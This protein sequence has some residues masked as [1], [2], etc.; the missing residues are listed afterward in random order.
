MKT[1]ILLRH[2]KSDWSNPEFADHQR[3]LNP[4]GQRNAP[5]MG[6]RMKSFPDYKPQLIKVSNAIR[7]RQTMELFAPAAGWDEVDLLVKDWLYLASKQEYIKSIE[8]LH[9]E[10]DSIC[11]CGHNP[12]VTDVVNYFTE[13]DIPNIPTCGIAVIT[14][15]VDSWKLVSQN[16]GKLVHYDY[17]KNLA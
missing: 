2:A 5:E 14:F 10:L 8:K 17:P 4:R 3:P 13:V 11:Y 9:D 7:T 12:T 6:E 15:N 1:V 16:S